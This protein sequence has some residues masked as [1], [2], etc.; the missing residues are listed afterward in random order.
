MQKIFQWFKAGWLA[1]KQC[2]GVKDAKSRRP[3]Y[4]S[5][6]RLDWILPQQLAVGRFPE[7]ENIAQLKQAKIQ[8][9]LCLCPPG[10]L[11]LS[12]EL[13]QHFRCICF[14]LPD[15]HYSEK[16]TTAQ[17]NR[18]VG[19]IDQALRQ[20]RPVYVHCREGIERSPTV[21]IAYLCKFQQM[22]LW[23]A[24]NLVKQVRPQISPSHSQVKAIRAFLATTQHVP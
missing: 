23:R 22:D 12:P 19:I 3:K 20:Q 1:L 13:Q 17:L 7:N 11:A 4:I 21:C 15:S 8:V 9:I 5:K 2:L 14:P 6:F 16:I 10:E 18:V 24:F